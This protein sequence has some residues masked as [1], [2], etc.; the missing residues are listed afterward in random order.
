MDLSFCLNFSNNQQHHI[1]MDMEYFILDQK[2]NFPKKNESDAFSQGTQP[3]KDNH[4]RVQ[5]KSCLRLPPP[6]G[7]FCTQAL[8]HCI[9]PIGKFE[10]SDKVNGLE[11]FGS[12]PLLTSHSNP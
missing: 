7:Q 4:S 12:A 6:T 8:Q 9:K 3:L 5:L 11:L 1:G 10:E 2:H